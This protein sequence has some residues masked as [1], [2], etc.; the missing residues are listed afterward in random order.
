MVFSKVIY[1]H[2]QLFLSQSLTVEL[3]YAGGSGCI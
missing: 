3:W 1:L 2:L